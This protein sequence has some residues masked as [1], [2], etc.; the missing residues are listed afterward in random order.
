MGKSPARRHDA[1]QDG[2]AAALTRLEREGTPIGCWPMAKKPSAFSS[3]RRGR[4]AQ[5]ARP[6]RFYP[7]GQFLQ[8]GFKEA[9][10]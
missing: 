2:L 1:A 3:Q 5:A 10:A 8:R 9:G 7:S 4:V 6:V